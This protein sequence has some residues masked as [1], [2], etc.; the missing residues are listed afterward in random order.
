[1]G[2]RHY[3]YCTIDDDKANPDLN[4]R[5][6]FS[7]SCPH[8]NAG[9]ACHRLTDSLNQSGHWVSLNLYRQA[10]EL[11]VLVCRKLQVLKFTPCLACAPIWKIPQG[12]VIHGCLHDFWP[13][14]QIFSMLFW[15]REHFCWERKKK[16]EDCCSLQHLILFE[17]NLIYK[18]FQ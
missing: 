11:G 17:H 3:Q 4:R 2:S 16:R 6:R 7:L 12:I 13:F 14:F 9:S 1:M 15:D 8:P 10:V 18:A 5:R